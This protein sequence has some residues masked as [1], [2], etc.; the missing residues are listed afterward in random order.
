MCTIPLTNHD[1]I[2]FAMAVIEIDIDIHARLRIYLFSA[3]L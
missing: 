1:G 3:N 2:K